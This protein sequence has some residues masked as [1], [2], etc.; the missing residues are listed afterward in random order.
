MLDWLSNDFVP[1]V[2]SGIVGLGLSI[3]YLATSVFSRL[4]S[5]RR[6]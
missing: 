3:V 2:F 6:H 4:R 5:N 1:W